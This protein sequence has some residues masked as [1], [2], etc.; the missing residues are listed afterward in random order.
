MDDPIPARI[1]FL[2][3]RWTALF[4][5]L[6]GTLIMWSCRVPDPP[7]LKNKSMGVVYDTAMEDEIRS[8]K[9]HALVMTSLA[10][11]VDT[12]AE[13]VAVTD[14]SDDSSSWNI[15][16]ATNRGWFESPGEPEAANQ[17]LD[18][19]Q[20][21]LCNVTL[22]RHRKGEEFQ[23]KNTKSRVSTVSASANDGASAAVD[24]EP[25]TE[26]DFLAGVN[27][28]VERSRQHDL[29]VFI[30]GFNVS[31]ESA[32]ARTAQLALDIPFNGAAVAY[33]WPTQGGVMKY[34]SDEPINKAS[35][36]PFTQF[37]TT[38]REGVPEDTRI[39]IVVHSMGNRIV[40]ESLSDL[41]APE[42]EK[43]FT[44]VVLCAPDV[45]RSDFEKWAPG[46]VAH[47][48]RVTLYA[49]MSDSAL[50]ASKGL[51]SEAR[52]GDA[53]KPVIVDGIETVDCSRVDLT[54]M[55][56]SYFGGNTDVLGDLF[57]LLKEDR[58]ASKRPHL[59]KKKQGKQAYWQFSRTAPTIMYTWHYEE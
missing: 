1:S 35:V 41:P 10:S 4:C 28:L 7:V 51:H 44:N 36:A 59:D 46:V 33:C 19:P 17:V 55:G 18:E 45:G 58:P 6:V 27:D 37:L 54:M 2:P 12:L 26:A 13:S 25:L 8:G 49:N 56:H 32:V 43:P 3:R 21:G 50:I 15:Y 31:F 29:L 9:A 5:A 38:L 24:S 22:P 30:H 48:E 16:V 14:W 57:M 42:G 23:V 34:S 53:W 20:Y 47:S 39:H 52:A 40:M 11:Y